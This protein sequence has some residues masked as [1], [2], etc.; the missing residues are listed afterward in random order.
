M[1]DYFVRSSDGS[2]ADNGLSWANAKLTVKG[3]NDVP[4][5][6]G[7]TAFV[8]DNYAEL[9]AAAISLASTGTAAAPNRYLCVDDAGDPGSPTTLATTATIGT[10]GSNSI[11]FTGYSYWYGFTFTA[12]NS[13]NNGSLI[14]SSASA[15]GLVLEQC[16]LAIG[17]TNGAAR[18]II[19]DNASNR[20]RCLVRMIDTD[21]RFTNVGH[22]FN[23]RDCNFEWFGGTVLGTMPTGGLLEFT[24]GCTG[25]LV[26][27]GVDLS[28]LGAN[29]IID[30]GTGD[31]C[32]EIYLE[33][34]KLGSS[35]VLTTGSFGGPHSVKIFVD[36]C[37]S[38]DTNYKMMHRSYEGS[39]D[40]DATVYRTGGASDG[41]TPISWLMSTSANVSFHYPLR[42]P[43]IFIWND[44]VGS[45]VTLTVEIVTNNVTPTDA[46]AWLEVDLMGTSGFPIATFV[47]DAKADTLA[48]A[49]NQTSS[50]ETW[51]NA[52]GTPLKFK[53]SK[54]FTPQEKGFL[55]A[56]VCF[57]KA[58]FPAYVCP[59]PDLT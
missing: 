28:P 47:D 42:S 40:A 5:A 29:P 9:P 4:A 25:K 12:A 16:E 17:G 10:T 2:D 36:N 39:V 56:R 54:A 37:D 48:T 57:A 23:F 14:V 22:S 50:S 21:V 26:L 11:T 35:F 20:A 43:D 32:G 55:R 44:T 3:V 34:C 58:S 8:S 27:R 33:R 24:V 59:K 6:A 18:I 51:N 46:E 52:P 19:G 1:T 41:T 53:L 30:I 31:W 38:G 45:S 15:V 49:A 7:S 13:T